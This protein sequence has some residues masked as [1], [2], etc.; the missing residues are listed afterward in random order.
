MLELYGEHHNL[1]PFCLTIIKGIIV[2]NKFFIVS[3][4]TILAGVHFFL[5]INTE[6]LDSTAIEVVLA[7]IIGVVEM[8]WRYIFLKIQDLNRTGI[9]EA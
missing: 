1:P 7:N 6:A 4:L 9:A 5:G 3:V 2:L 8:I